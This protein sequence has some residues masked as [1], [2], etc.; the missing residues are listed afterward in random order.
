MFLKLGQ[1]P[2]IVVSSADSAEH[3][4]KSHDHVFSSRPT[5]EANTFLDY[6]TGGLAF[7]KYG[8][9]WPNMRKFC[10]I[11]LL[12]ASKVDSFEPLRKKELQQAVNF[13]QKAAMDGEVVDLSERIH[14]VVE[15]FVYKM[16]LGRNKDAEHPRVM[17]NLQDELDNVV[18]RNKLVE[19]NDLAK[20]SYLDIK[21]TSVIINLWAIGRDAKTWSDNAEVFYPERFIN[22]NLDY[23]GNGLQ[24]M[25][26]GFGRRGCPG[27]LLGVTT[28][29]LLVAQLVHCFNWELP[30][31]IAPIDLD[32]TEKSGFSTPRLN[33][34]LAVPRYRS[35][36]YES[37]WWIS[38]LIFF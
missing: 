29:K 19:E 1:V 3:F 15:D 32:M 12:S 16:V 4:L 33:H 38:K 23:R 28:V 30:Q 10:T 11:Q 21:N 20:L 17:K 5:H 34:L 2:T 37:S 6:G 24:F 35:S 27:M 9:Y 31:N 7:S 22:S 18:G 8:A 25:P 36:S 13:L 26:F 14:D